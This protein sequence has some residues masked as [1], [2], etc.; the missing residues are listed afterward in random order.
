[1]DAPAQFEDFKLNRQ[2]LNAIAEAGYTQPTPV[3][4]QAIPLA[5]A[6]HDLIAIAQTGTGKTA[7]FLLPL[8]MKLK[9]AQGNDPRGLVLAPTR[10]LVI[11]IE[12]HAQQL[13]TYTD[14]RIHALYGG[15]GIQK[16]IQDLQSTGADLLIATPQRLWDIY[17]KQG[18]NLRKIQTFVM[19]EADRMLDMGF[20]RQI[21]HLLEI[22]PAKKRQ[23]MLFSATM[24]KSVIRLTEEFLEAPERVTITPTATTAQTITQCWYAVPNRPTKLQLRKYLI[25]DPEEMAKVLVFAQTKQTVNLIHDYLHNF[26]RGGWRVI[27]GNKDQNARL[28][29]LD[30]FREGNVR[31]LVATSVA[32]RGL[33]ISAVTHVINFE[34]PRD[35]DDYVHRIGRTGRAQHSGI[36]ISFCN[37]VERYHLKKIEKRIRQRI[38]E[39]P[40]PDEITPVFTP[41]EE[42]Q[43]IQRELDML[44]RRDD[45]TF[46]GAFH[47]KKRTYR[48]KKSKKR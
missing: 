47:E 40:L 24:P 37:E 23:N 25:R 48:T 45:P 35:Y 16:Q 20:V 41:K 28:N 34:M 4:S 5:L 36:A 38:P 13:A 43:E 14:L 9:Y 12:S 27:H 19:D 11:Q 21:N 29:A 39:Q 7:A 44:R 30:D 32:A 3:Q 33:D 18:V 6:G 1:M 26:V 31:L 15:I 17:Q 2:L 42:F 46:K 22:I 8:L 10:E